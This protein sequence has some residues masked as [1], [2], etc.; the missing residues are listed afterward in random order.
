MYFNHNQLS[1]GVQIMIVM[2]CRSTKRTINIQDPRPSLE[3]HS[4]SLDV[5]ITARTNNATYR[6][7]TEASQ[8]KAK[9]VIKQAPSSGK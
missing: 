8:L 3:L 4:V 2:L 6:T 7:H 1:L 9:T 5:T